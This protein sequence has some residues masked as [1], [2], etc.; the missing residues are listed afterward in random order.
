MYHSSC[1]GLANYLWSSIYDVCFIWLFPY[2][3]FFNLFISIVLHKYLYFIL[4]YCNLFYHLLM[5][6]LNYS[7]QHA[8]SFPPPSLQSFM[9][10]PYYKFSILFCFPC[11]VSG[12]PAG[13]KIR[14][15]RWWKFSNSPICI[16]SSYYTCLYQWIMY[17][18]NVPT[19]ASYVLYT[20][21]IHTNFSSRWRRGNGALCALLSLSYTLTHTKHT[22]PF[23]LEISV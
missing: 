3:L 20:H 16:Y 13:K 10:H 9:C 18:S 11:A 6:K 5:I 22:P 7:S 12:R 14:N 4:L 19:Y 2:H 21:L 1:F 17:A 8:C 23:L 15:G